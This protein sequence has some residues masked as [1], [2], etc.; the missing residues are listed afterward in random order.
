MNIFPGRLEDGA[1]RAGPFH[2]SPAPANESFRGREL[3]VGIR[4]EHVHVTAGR[5]TRAH[6]EV[7]EVA[8]SETFVHLVTDGESLVARVPSHRRPETGQTV[9]VS[10]DSAH[11]YF[12]VATTGEGLA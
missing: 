4:P 2:F 12:F 9:R 11:A 3:E 8:G 5:G 1:L 6:V 7:L 10:A